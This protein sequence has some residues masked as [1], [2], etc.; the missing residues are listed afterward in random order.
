MKK[1]IALVG[2]AWIFTGCATLALKPHERIFN[3]TD[4]SN[5]KTY[6]GQTVGGTRN[7]N[8]PF[9]AT[10]E[11]KIYQGTWVYTIGGGSYS[12][13]SGSTGTYSGG[14]YGSA[15]TRTSAV[16]VPT[17]GSGVVNL[18]DGVG[19]FLKC[20][21]DFSSI[22]ETGTGQCKRNDGRIFDLIVH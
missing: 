15:S 16:S 18:N 17:Q 20:N 19:G 2:I 13:G 1:T 10:I 4:T 22:T 21:F 8:G 7:Y 12:Q 14:V 11:D 3:F 5:G 9:Q 6:S